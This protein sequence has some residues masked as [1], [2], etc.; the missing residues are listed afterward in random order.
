MNIYSSASTAVPISFAGGWCSA[1]SS[2]PSL[3]SQ[4]SVVP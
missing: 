2:A 4:E 1:S 3:I